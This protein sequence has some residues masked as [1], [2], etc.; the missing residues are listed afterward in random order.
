MFQVRDFVAVMRPLLKKTIVASIIAM[1]V[2]VSTMV[3]GISFIALAGAG[4]SL[5]INGS[6]TFQAMDGFGVNAGAS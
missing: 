1:L 3:I 2:S 6:H 4:G 5:T